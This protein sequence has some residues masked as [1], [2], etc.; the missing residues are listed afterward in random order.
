MNK[1]SIKKDTRLE[2]AKNYV[3]EQLAIMKKHGTARR[4][5]P[6]EYQSLIRKVARATTK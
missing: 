2:P 6:K 5:S 1:T 4:I 3:D